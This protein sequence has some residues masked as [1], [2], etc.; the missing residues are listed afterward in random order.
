MKDTLLIGLAGAI[1]VGITW[2]VNWGSKKK[3]KKHGRRQMYR[4]TER[5]EH[6]RRIY[7]SDQ[8]SQIQHKIPEMVGTNRKEIGEAQKSALYNT[9]RRR[10]ETARNTL[11]SLQQNKVV[12]DCI[13]KTHQM[14]DGSE[15]MCSSHEMFKLYQTLKPSTKTEMV[16]PSAPERETVEQLDDSPVV[17]GIIS[18]PEE[19]NSPDVDLD[20]VSV[21]S[22]AGISGGIL[23]FEEDDAPLVF[24]RR[25]IISSFSFGDDNDLKSWNSEY[26]D[27]KSVTPDWV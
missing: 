14:E 20:N 1:S 18:Y 9:L 25:E 13:T 19:N 21:T 26:S 6:P 8:M 2:C 17:S 16:V 12:K 22:D 5:R 10:L 27:V 11:G 15:M 4:R 23:E 24:D 3:H 7:V